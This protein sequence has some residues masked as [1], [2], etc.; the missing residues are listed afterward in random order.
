MASCFLGTLR[1]VDL[2]AVCLVASIKLFDCSD[3]ISNFQCDFSVIAVKV[4]SCVQFFNIKIR[5]FHITAVG[6]KTIV[7]D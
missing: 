2:R 6:R 1:P 4:M 3:Y 7:L 5:I